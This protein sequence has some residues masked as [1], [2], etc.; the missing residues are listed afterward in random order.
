[1]RTSTAGVKHPVWWECIRYE[2]PITIAAI[3][4]T[5][6]PRSV[7][8]RG[9]EPV[10]RHQ[11]P[12]RRGVP[13]A[14]QGGVAGHLQQRR[15][16]PDHEEE[17]QPQPEGRPG[18]PLRSTDEEP[19]RNLSSHLRRSRVTITEQSPLSSAG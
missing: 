17:R 16:E 3:Q 15:G 11:N 13:P 7:H 6:T 18:Y 4:S 14:A 1:M 10:A 9:A 2:D 19:E 5:R 8:A 12:V